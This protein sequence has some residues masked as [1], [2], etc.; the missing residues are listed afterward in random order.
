MHRTLRERGIDY[1]IT[2]ALDSICWTEG[3]ED[4][5][6]L[7]NQRVRWQ[8]G[9]ADTLLFNIDLMFHRR[10]ARLDGL[11]FPSCLF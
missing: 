6:T 5:K 8:R 11:R 1:R 4:F 2:Y 9:L 3:P 10:V 7:K